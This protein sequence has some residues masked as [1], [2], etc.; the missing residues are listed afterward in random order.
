MEGLADQGMSWE[1]GWDCEKNEAKSIRP[2]NNGKSRIC[3]ER[4]QLRGTDSRNLN[5]LVV[6]TSDK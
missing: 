2:K 5:I 3:I 4:G 1:T 6:T